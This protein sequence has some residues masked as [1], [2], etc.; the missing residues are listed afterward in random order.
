M[1]PSILLF[2]DPNKLDQLFYE[3]VALIDAG[4]LGR[5]ESFLTTNPIVA[6]ERLA[7]PGPWLCDKF[8][9]KLPGFF[10]RPY[11]LWFV[12]EDPVRAGRL[13][14]NIE[15]MAHAIIESVRREKSANLQEQLDYALRLV[16]WSTVARKCGVQI[17]LIDVLADAGASLAGHPDNALVNG[18]IAAA[19]HL[20]RRGSSL[21][22]ATALCLG[23]WADVQS[24]AVSA[25]GP[26]QQFALVLA[27]LNGKAEALRQMIRLGVDINAPS[28]DLYSHGTPLHH[29]VC[30]GSIEAVQ[31]LVEAGANLHAPDTAWH[32]T[33]LGWALHYVEEKK[34]AEERAC[35]EKI[36]T[37]LRQRIAEPP[38][39]G[40]SRI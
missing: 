39:I 16:S 8:G 29:A 31:A 36:A 12:A 37:Y 14:K 34:Q 20:V 11:L 23:R 22:L 27:A 10:Q 28:Q 38:A 5:L 25:G 13:P 2:M 4:D 15:Q 21:T 24:L 19:E 30:S 33:P 9:G 7:E 17:K 1:A 18:N 40:T 32:G 6:Q 3:A 35:Y 26:E